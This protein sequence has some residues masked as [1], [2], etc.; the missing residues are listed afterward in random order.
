M[1]VREPASVLRP[2]DWVTYDDGDHQVTALA[3]TSVRLRSQAG[4]ETVVLAS[5]LMASPGFCVTGTEPLP[6]VEPFG[7]LKALPDA[8]LAA[9]REWERHVVE[10]ET[11]LPLDAAPGM[12]PRPEYDP[13]THSVVERDTAKAAELGVVVR[14]VQG[15]RYAY[16]RQGL[17]GLVDQ[18][19]IRVWEATGRADARL[20]TAI[21]EAIKAETHSSTGTRS[22]LIRRVIKAVE[23]AHGPGVVPLPSKNTFYKLI[24]TLSA[25]RHTFGSAVT[26]RQ[27]ANRPKGPFTPTFAARPGEQ[28]QIDSTPLD[29]M[30]VLDSGLK[31]R[32]DLLTSARQ[33]DLP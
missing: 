13:A 14:T 3:G 12:T 24:D 21:E 31:V 10:V 6:E 20:V 33:G 22:R 25:G 8:V 23:A 11:G 17:W 7:L 16:A 5:Y 19:A 4:A 18:R 1:M 27:Q 26:R 28:V 9:A 15:K 30:V 32:T 29:V 2:G